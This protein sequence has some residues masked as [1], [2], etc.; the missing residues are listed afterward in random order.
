MSRYPRYT[1]E[2]NQPPIY[3][4]EEPMPGWATLACLFAGALLGTMF[5]LLL[6][7]GV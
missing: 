4:D 1:N 5:V 7:W 2:R 6:I 3:L